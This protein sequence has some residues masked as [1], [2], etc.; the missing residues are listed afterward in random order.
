LF[1]QNNV[2]AEIK[3]LKSAKSKKLKLP[4]EMVVTS[5]ST[6]PAKFEADYFSRLEGV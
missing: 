2:Q 1:K 4:N 5:I 6:P 3:L